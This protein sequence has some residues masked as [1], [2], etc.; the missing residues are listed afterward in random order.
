MTES[1]YFCH[2]VAEGLAGWKDFVGQTHLRDFS[3]HCDEESTL[4]NADNL[5]YRV[6]LH[7]IQ[8]ETGARIRIQVHVAMLSV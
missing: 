2:A 4:Q 6:M 8:V 5:H 1:I 3:M 7:V